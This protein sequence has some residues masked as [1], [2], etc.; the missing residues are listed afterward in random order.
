MGVQL[1]R[2]C[3][4]SFAGWYPLKRGGTACLQTAKIGSQRQIFPL[5]A[6][7]LAG[8]PQLARGC[9]ADPG[10]VGDLLFGDVQLPIF[11]QAFGNS[12]H[13]S[14]HVHFLANV[15]HVG[16]NGFGSDVELAADFLVNK[17][18]R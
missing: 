10:C 12:L 4:N 1:Q 6:G 8:V 15:L 13:A 7:D 9:R 11:Q 18:H 17:S 2:V 3:H 16:S 5:N 14:T